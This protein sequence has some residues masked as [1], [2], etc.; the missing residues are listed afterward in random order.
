MRERIVKL[1]I[2]SLLFGMA[3]I[4]VVGPMVSANATTCTQTVRNHQTVYNASEN[5]IY[6]AAEA[7]GVCSPAATYTKASV[8]VQYSEDNSPD[9]YTNTTL[10]NG[11][12]Q[13]NDS[14]IVKCNCDTLKVK[15]AKNYGLPS[16]YYRLQI[17]I[18]NFN[19]KGTVINSGFHYGGIFHL[20]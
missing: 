14:G 16:G 2:L 5:S 18:W 10:P 17:G 12:V 15:T 11:L 1:T 6:G 3:G 8:C 19:S 20:G 9:S 13:C 4:C 7:G